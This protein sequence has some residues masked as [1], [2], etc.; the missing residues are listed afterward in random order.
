MLQMGIIRDRV[1]SN[2]RIYFLFCFHLKQM[3]HQFECFNGFFQCK[4]IIITIIM[5]KFKF[6]VI[7]IKIYKD[8]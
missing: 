2:Y 5:F 7:R 3:S 8:K 4:F 6:K 1:T